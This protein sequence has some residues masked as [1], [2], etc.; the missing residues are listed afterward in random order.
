MSTDLI[1]YSFVIRKLNEKYSAMVPD[2]DYWNGRS[3]GEFF[4][5]YRDEV[6][7]MIKEYPLIEFDDAR[8]FAGL[9]ED[10]LPFV[11]EVIQA[12]LYS[13]L[14]GK[15]VILLP[16]YSNRVFH[17]IFS[18]KLKKGSIGD[19]FAALA[20]GGEYMEFKL[21]ADK[22]LPQRITAASKAA[23]SFFICVFSIEDETIRKIRSGRLKI[24]MEEGKYGYIF[25]ISKRKLYRLEKNKKVTLDLLD[26]LPAMSWGGR[27]DNVMLPT[28]DIVYSESFSGVNENNK[29]AGKGLHDLLPER[30]WGGRIDNIVLSTAAAVYAD[31]LIAVNWTLVIDFHEYLDNESMKYKVPMLLIC[32]DSL[33]KDEAMEWARKLSMRNIR[34][35][36][37]ED[38]GISSLDASSI[39]AAL[40]FGDGKVADKFAEEK[41]IQCFHIDVNSAFED[42]CFPTVACQ[43]P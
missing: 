25:D 33:R 30:I 24:T 13:L 22:K 18:V 36:I 31:S 8:L 38:S 14:L 32:H 37:L 29:E 4:S 15:D 6:T 16:R 3:V 28:A 11:K 5:L 42:V 17:S 9:V 21:C 43:I 39:T 20:D 23:D 40:V 27:T 41:G 35:N 12:K 7:S 2:K 34:V 19:G 26:L 1:D 10:D